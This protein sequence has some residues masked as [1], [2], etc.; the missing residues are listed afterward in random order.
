MT[1]LDGHWNVRRTGGFLPPMVGVRKTISGERG[2]TRVGPLPGVPFSVDGLSLRYVRPLGSFVDVLEADG[3]GF[4][5]RS[6]FRGRELGTFELR[7][8]ASEGA[9]AG[10]MED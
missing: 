4:K 5:G 8:P 2:H 9:P 3:H 7:R 6:L 10:K 1:D